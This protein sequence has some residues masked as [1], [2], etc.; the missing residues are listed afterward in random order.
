MLS[1]YMGWVCACAGK[2]AGSVH[3]CNVMLYGMDF[4]WWWPLSAQT[5]MKNRSCVDNQRHCIDIQYID[6]FHLHVY[7]YKSLTNVETQTTPLFECM[8]NL[9]FRKYKI[10][11]C[12]VSNCHVILYVR[13]YTSTIYT[14]C[15]GW[16]DLQIN[17]WR[18]LF[19]K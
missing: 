4:S 14:E 10:N 11:L 17:F 9:C 2:C 8:L 19:T 12:R 15:C 13:S 6:L 16:R 18:V 5:P 1:V 3:S 7:F